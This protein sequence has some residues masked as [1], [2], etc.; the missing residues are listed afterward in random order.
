MPEDPR[1]KPVSGANLEVAVNYLKQRMNDGLDEKLNITDISEWAKAATKPTYT[2]GEIGALPA[3][4]ESTLAKKSDLASILRWKGSVA[5][6]NDLP[7]GLGENEIG[8][9]YNVVSEGGMNFGW[10]GTGWDAAGSVFQLD[11]LTDEEVLA[12]L[13]GGSS[14]G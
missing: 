11:F 6:M 8:W 1:T 13:N 14:N 5:T 7:T 10:T 3:S 4:I 2:P 9:T 12:I